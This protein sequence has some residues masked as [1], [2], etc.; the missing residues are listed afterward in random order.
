LVLHPDAFLRRTII[1]PDAREIVLPPP[2][3][4]GIELRLSTDLADSS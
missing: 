3:R 2:D 1:L 4:T